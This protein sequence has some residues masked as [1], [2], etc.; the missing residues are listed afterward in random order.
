[1]AKIGIEEFINRRADGPPISLHKEDN[2][3]L[4]SFVRNLYQQ[5]KI[6]NTGKKCYLMNSDYQKLIR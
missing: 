2:L 5:N 6:E 1:M 4:K 3:Y